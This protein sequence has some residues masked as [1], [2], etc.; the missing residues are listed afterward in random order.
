MKRRRLL[1]SAAGIAGVSIVGSTPVLGQGQGRDNR[2]RSDAKQL[3]DI[4]VEAEDS[5]SSASNFEEEF[6][7]Y[8]VRF[9]GEYN[10]EEYREPARTGPDVFGLGGSGDAFWFGVTA[11]DGEDIQ[12]EIKHKG[13]AVLYLTDEDGDRYEIRAQFDGQGNLVHVNGVSP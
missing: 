5:D 8:V 6:T 4:T 12:H 11:P 2:R 9:P 7:Y 1:R 10:F 3:D 13:Q